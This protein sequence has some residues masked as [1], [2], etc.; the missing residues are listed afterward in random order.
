[1]GM[2]LKHQGLLGAQVILVTNEIVTDKKH[3]EF[4]HSQDTDCFIY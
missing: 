2:Q 1:M 4:G 3:V